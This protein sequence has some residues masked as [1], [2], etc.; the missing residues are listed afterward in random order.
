ME[1]LEVSAKTVEEAIER[2][3]QQMGMTRDQVETAVLNKGKSGFLGHGCGRS[4]G[5]IDTAASSPRR[6]QSP[7]CGEGGAGR[8]PQRE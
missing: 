7:G 2:G 3:L 6:E 1:S 5:Q 8:D 4:R